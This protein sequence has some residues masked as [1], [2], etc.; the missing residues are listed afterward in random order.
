VPI[1]FAQVTGFG[2]LHGYP[3][4]VVANNGILFSESAQKGA[5]FIEVRGP[6]RRRRGARTS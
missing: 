4:G 3:V 6:V 2:R 5:H 1:P